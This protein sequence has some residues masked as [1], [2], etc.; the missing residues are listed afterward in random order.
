MIHFWISYETLIIA[1]IFADSLS[2]KKNS[3]AKLSCKSSVSPTRSDSSISVGED[4]NCGG[5]LF[6]PQNS[7]VYSHTYFQPSDMLSD[8]LLEDDEP[9]GM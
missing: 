5:E 7:S 3:S 1:R 8:F 6:K 4:S 9:D 2:R